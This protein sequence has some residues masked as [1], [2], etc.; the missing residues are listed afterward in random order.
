METTR[1]PRHCGGICGFPWDGWTSARR[2]IQRSFGSHG[3]TWL[4]DTV[5]PHD[6][7]SRSA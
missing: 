3:G 2:K 6:H 4:A 7:V 1:G 5:R